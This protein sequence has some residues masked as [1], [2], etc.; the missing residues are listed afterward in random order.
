MCQLVQD[1]ATIHI[2]FCFG[3]L[4]GKVYFGFAPLGNFRSIRLV[5]YDNRLFDIFTSIP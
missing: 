4:W 5:S 3:G 2:M 1:F